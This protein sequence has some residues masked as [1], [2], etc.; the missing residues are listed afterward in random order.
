MSG[1]DSFTNLLS[2]ISASPLGQFLVKQQVALLGP[3]VLILACLLY[4][5][6]QAFSKSEQER[7]EI[8]GTAFIGVS[9][10]LFF[11]I[12]QFWL[13]FVMTGSPATTSYSVF[14]GMFQADLFSMLIRIMM[15]IGAFVVMLMTRRYIENRSTMP[16]EFYVLFL[17]ALLGSMLLAGSYDLIMV[18]VALETLGISSYLMAGYIR[19]DQKSIEASLKY[20]LYGGISTAVLLFGFSLL[21]GYARSTGFPEIATALASA[22]GAMYPLI[23]VM[24][25]LILAGLAF[26]LS[27]APFHMWAPDVY[28][29][30]PTPV[31]AFLSV[32]SKIA[33]FA[34]T[35]RLLYGVMAPLQTWFVALA[36]VSVLSMT[37]GN[38]V[39]LCQ[40]NIKRLLAYSTI[41]HAGY[42]LLGL[43]S[44]TDFGGASMMYYLLTYVFMNLGAFAV[45]IHFSNVTGSDDISS[46]AGLVQK[47]PALVLAFSFFLLSLSGM[48]ITAGFFAKFFLFQSLAATG[49]QHLWLIIVALINSTIS[50]YYYL[51]IIRLMVIAE[52]SHEVLEMP[53]HDDSTKNLSAMGMAV[54]VCLVGTLLLGFYADPLMKISKDSIHQLSSNL[55][56][57]S[58]REFSMLK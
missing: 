53:K 18:F 40:K 1:F 52:P 6:K 50:M 4:T 25:V 26:K 42:I 23:P 54:S 20:L 8:W 37:I 45:V 13:M 15:L 56:A 12:F 11:V 41:A 57:Y 46:Y 7:Q 58:G 33:G 49:T 51:N 17:G 28:E 35:V 21:Y 39:A 27:A 29:G 2:G 14:F 47:R 5:I 43:I 38:V 24:T 30:A 48:P 19:G 31:T 22:Q 36:I 34:V 32:V 55:K 44:M 10:A 16:G 9:F 3:E